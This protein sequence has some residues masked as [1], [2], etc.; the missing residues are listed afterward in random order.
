VLKIRTM[1]VSTPLDV[2]YAVVSASPNRFASSYTPRGPT[3]L[4]LPQYSSV[5]GCCSGSPYTSDVEARTYRASFS[6]A[7]P[8]VCRVPRL[9]TLSVSIGIRR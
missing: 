2:R 4:T 1:P 7:S 8:R 9:P 3:G 6:M 5:C